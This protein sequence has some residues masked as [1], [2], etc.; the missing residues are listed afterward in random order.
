VEV[1][2]ATFFDDAP[3]ILAEKL[4]EDSAQLSFE[5]KTKDGEWVNID[6][7][8]EEE[9]N[10]PKLEMQAFR[11]DAETDVNDSELSGDEHDDGMGEKNEDAILAVEDLTSA[12]VSEGKV[13]QGQAMDAVQARAWV[14]EQ[15]A[16]NEDV[17]AFI[18]NTVGGFDHLVQCL[19]LPFAYS[20]CFDEQ[21]EQGQN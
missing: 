17:R 7:V 1:P 10:R 5:L 12:A 15:A 6:D 4:G 11:D 3:L 14:T 18:L 21:G 13:Q 16:V 2:I 19:Q 9:K 20:S 8:A